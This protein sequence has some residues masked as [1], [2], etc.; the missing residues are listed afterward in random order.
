MVTLLG[1]CRSGSAISDGVSFDFEHPSCQSTVTVPPAGAVDVRFLGAGGVYVGWGSDA[2][3]AGPFFSNPPLSRQLGNMHHDRARIAQHLQTVPVGKVRAIITGHS[4]YDHLGDVPVVA[5]EYATGAAIYGNQTG[6]NMLEPYAALK[7][8][9]HVIRANDVVDV[10]DRIRIRAVA[11]DHAP[12]ICRS[13]R[14]P[15][16][17]SNCSLDHP[18]TT[19]FESHPLRD[20]C[21]GETLAYV[22][23]LIEND[24]VRYRI[25]YNDSSPEAPMGIPAMSDGISFDL[26]ILCI[27]SYD[28]V[29]GYPESLLQAIQPAHVIIIH[30]EDFFARS[31]GH[32]RFVPELTDA[33]VRRFVE[34]M[35]SAN[36][37]HAFH[38]PTNHVCG[39]SAPDFTMPVVGE[40]MLFQATH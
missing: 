35:R 30:W 17:I 28:K 33:K 8:R 37:G 34:R 19:P 18:W 32:W 9:T 29:D 21:G 15:C 2:I 10:S 22:I 39:A 11:S 12:Q 13:R 7:A 23:D 27:A 14:W 24:A 1:H 31:E 25:Y 5:G 40:Q 6:V 16:D 26:A 4:H 20:F 38:P 3:L 36:A